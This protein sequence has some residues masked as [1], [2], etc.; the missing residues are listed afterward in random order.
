ML[1]A[2]LDRHA[3][4]RPHHEALVTADERLTYALLLRRVVALSERMEAQGVAPGTVVPLLLDNDTHF[5]VALVA[6]LRLGA[7]P[8]PLPPSGTQGERREM[9]A[10]RAIPV[11]LV[12]ED[13]PEEPDLASHVLRAPFDQ[14][15]EPGPVGNN[16][17]AELLV[18]T[19]GSTGQPKVARLSEAG[20]V[21]NALAHAESIG[22]EGHDRLLVVSPMYHSATLVAQLLAALWHGATLVLMRGPF[23]PRAYLKAVEAERV[24]VSALTPTHVRLIHDKRSM[25]SQ[26][27]AGA[28]LS[29][30][31]V[32]TVGAAPVEPSLVRAF[33]A[34]LAEKC[35][36]K[37]F[38]TYGLT[39]A[40]PRVTTLPAEALAERSESVGL[41]LRGVEVRVVST[42]TGEP[43][44]PG[45]EGELQVRTPSR[46]LGYLGEEP[47]SE[48]WLA[49]GDLAVV[50]AEGYV[51]LRGRLK[52]IIVTGGSNV[53]PWEV[54]R[55]L[56]ADARIHE[57]AVVGEP[58]G[59]FGEIVHAY[60]VPAG[61][62]TS[63]ELLQSLSGL[64]ATYKLPR[65]LTLVDRLPRTPSGKVDKRRLQAGEA[66]S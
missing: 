21:W 44:A 66:T 9:L 57:A 17:G 18:P 32:V 54:E 30:L 50:D 37:V 25:R 40:G 60:V 8:L 16:R 45:A 12:N 24:T 26:L 2:A 1:N 48:P 10:G 55:A 35:P 34:E 29:S 15:A 28:D 62:V 41:P 4:S 13:L 3:Q 47:W 59:V 38:V 27:V 5:V 6:A 64:L 46:M 65:K 22:L 61:E 43:L 51:T 14:E 7:R 53:S 52:E 49:T 11:A 19:S 63:E 36:A 31:R 56:C 20:S 33:A 23:M 42:E 58:H 39:E